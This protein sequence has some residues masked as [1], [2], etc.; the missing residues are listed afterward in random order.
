MIKFESFASSS[1]GNLYTVTSGE[2]KLLLECGLRYS[3]IEE[4]VRYGLSGYAGCLLS[5]EHSDHSRSAKKLVS[6]GVKLYTSAG[7]AHALGL[8]GLCEVLRVGHEYRIGGLDVKPFSV[9]HDAAEP[10]G[11]LLRDRDDLMIF[12]TDTAAIPVKVD[13]LTIIA[14]ECNHDRKLITGKAAWERRAQLSHMSIDR[15]IDWLRAQ[16]RSKLRELYLLHLSDRY[17]SEPDFLER[18][19]SRL[20]ITATACPH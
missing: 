7:T 1:A 2:T 19:H 13:G 17:A 10:L 5:H 12:A 20:G 18:I 6:H 11:F 8:D 4:A 3:T 14:V 15:T 16:D 9:Y